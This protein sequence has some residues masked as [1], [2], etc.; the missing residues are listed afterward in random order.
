MIGSYVIH[1]LFSQTLGSTSSMYYFGPQRELIA[2]GLLFQPFPK[3]LNY[4][5]STQAALRVSEG[6]V[7]ELVAAGRAREALLLSIR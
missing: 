3:L 1:M 4:L 5:V 7:R 2:A 6:R